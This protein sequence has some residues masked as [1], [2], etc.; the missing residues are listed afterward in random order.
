MYFESM[1]VLKAPRAR[2]LPLRPDGSDRKIRYEEVKVGDL[3]LQ[4]ALVL[5]GLGSRRYCD[6]LV[7]QGLIEVNGKIASI[8]MKVSD[9]DRI[10]Y[11]GRRLNIRFLGRIPRI[12]IYHKPE[13]EIVSRRDPQNRTTVFDRLPQISSSI[14]ASVGRLDLNSSGLLIF[15]TD[16]GL[17]NTM[18]HPSFRVDR[19]Y[20]VRIKGVWSE[21]IKNRLLNGIELNDGFAKF[22]RIIFKGGEKSNLWLHAIIKEGKQREVRRLFDAVGL[23]VSRLIRI[24]FGIIP[25][26]SRLKRGHYYELNPREV[27]NVLKWVK[28]IVASRHQS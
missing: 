22:D 19:E 13:G 24:R 9:K 11:R 12:L 14:W 26:P 18:T 4:K 21:E 6:G 17:A 7:S 8:G 3:R 2:R 5:S 23:M 16:G 20:A 10:C 28:N 15:T 27:S 1:N 25:L